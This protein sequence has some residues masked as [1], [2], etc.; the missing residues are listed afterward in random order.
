MNQIPALKFESGK[1]DHLPYR[2]L[3]SLENKNISLGS[4]IFQYGQSM[5]GNLLLCMHFCSV[6]LLN[7]VEM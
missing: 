3:L 4:V 2:V 6:L 7:D 5:F 1:D